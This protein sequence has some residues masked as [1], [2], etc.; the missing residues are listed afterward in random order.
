LG[1]TVRRLIFPPA[2][3]DEGSQGAQAESQ[4]KGPNH[5]LTPAQ[6]PALH[7][8]QKIS[9]LVGQAHAIS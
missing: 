4:A 1:R 6:L 2:R 7:L 8:E 3:L 5:E 9:D